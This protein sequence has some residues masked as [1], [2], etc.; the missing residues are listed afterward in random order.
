[1][2]FH[3]RLGKAPVPEYRK[4]YPEM[5]EVHAMTIPSLF[6]ISQEEPRLMP[7]GTPG[8]LI[9]NDVIVWTMPKN[10]Q[11]S[12]SA[13]FSPISSGSCSLFR[14]WSLFPESSLSSDSMA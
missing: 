12:G 2:Q 13:F 6:T 4:K 7:M 14:C 11:F 8:R 9:L 3:R 1:M 5:V 10:D